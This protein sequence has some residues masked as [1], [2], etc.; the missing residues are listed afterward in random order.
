MAQYRAIFQN[1][2]F[3][4]LATA[5]VVTA[6]LA[7]GQAQAAI[8]DAQ[9]WEG[10]TGTPEA[11][12]ELTI[13]GNVTATNGKEFVLTLSG[14]SNVINGTTTAATSLTA[15]KG[16]LILN[17]DNSTLTIGAATGDSGTKV[18]VNAL[19]IQNG[20][21]TLTNTTGSG[22]T[23]T[24]N[25]LNLGAKGKLV[26]SG[27]DAQAKIGDA[28]KTTINLASGGT[29]EFQSSGSVA[30][31]QLVGTGGTIHFS[32][33][34]A[35]TWTVPNYVDGTAGTAQKQNITVDAGK[36]G[37]IALVGNDTAKKRGVMDFA[38]GSVITLTSDNSSGGSL[39]IDS[40]SA[41]L[42]SLVI[43]REGVDLNSSGSG[44]SGGTITVKGVGSD[45]AEKISTLQTDATVL[46]N[47]LTASVKGS[48]LLDAHSEL[49]IDNRTVKFGTATALTDTDLTLQ[50]ASG[51]AAAGQ[52]SV[53]GATTISAQDMVIESKVGDLS[54]NLTL[55]ADNL[56]LGKT[57]VDMSTDGTGVKELKAKNV[58][59]IGQNDTTDFVLKDK[60]TLSNG[61]KVTGNVTVSG[62]G[63]FAI[64]GGNYSLS[65]KLT[66]NSGSFNVGSATSTSATNVSL[67]TLAINS[68]AANT[69]TVAGADGKTAKLDLTN[70]ELALTGNAQ[71]TTFST[72]NVNTHGQLDI[73]ADNFT[74]ILSNSVND[75]A[76]N[77]SG[78]AGFALSGGII[79]LG[80]DTLKL[81]ANVFT[82]G[83]AANQKISFNTGVESTL[84]AK[85][86]VLTETA[87]GGLN[88]G[89]SGNLAIADT[90]TIEN[91][92]GGTSGLNFVVKTG[93]LAVGS[94]IQSENTA[95][96][97]VLGVSGSSKATLTLGEIVSKTNHTADQGSINV[98]LS[99]I[100]KNQQSGSSLDIEYG[101]WDA[102]SIATKNANI[103]IGAASIN[104]LDLQD[105]DHKWG[106]NAQKLALGASGDT[107]NVYQNI[108]GSTVD[109]ELVVADLS[110]ASGSKINVHGDMTLN[111]NFS[112]GSNA[113]S[114]DDDTYGVDLKSGTIAMQAGGTLTIDNDA[115]TAINISGDTVTLKGYEAGS[116]A[117]ATGSTVK[118]NFAADYGVIS[119]AAI[120]EL[121][122]KLFGKT[123]DTDRLEG[124]LNLGGAELEGLVVNPETNEIAWKD[125]ETKK[126]IISDVTTSK[127]ENAEVTG[128]KSTDTVRGTFGSLTS[129]EMKAGSQIK[130]DENLTL[131]NAA[132][133]QGYFAAQVD[134]DG[135]EGKVLGALGFN[136][137]ANTNL[138][139]KNGGIADKI[140]LGDGSKL[141]VVGNNNETTLTKI[142]GNSGVVSLE[143][144]AL[145]VTHED[146]V[147]VGSLNS[148]A[149][150][151]LAANKLELKSTGNSKI[152]GDLNIA[153]KTTVS[154][155]AKFSGNNQFGDL[156]TATKNAVKRSPITR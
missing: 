19:D 9:G 31:K 95:A 53:S 130:T 61:E 5:A 82:S 78:T 15:E 154:G 135:N 101:T 28:T 63:P 38:S 88:L 16:T 64:D 150:S 153:G 102:Q 152:A 27:S 90:L 155:S 96:K 92:S 45:S 114:P 26:V 105:V 136:V 52:V 145:K 108:E 41:S 141:V 60:L 58:T 79:N 118:L 91:T 43:L 115:L 49:A 126:D 24:L 34:G 46:G 93:N 86:M 99:L 112:S 116:I 84:K 55:A 36:T 4:G 2:Y 76:T 156:F 37:T 18:S 35:N 148:K 10:L 146:G 22:S 14:T 81:N 119:D 120:V 123:A 54:A 107:V 7:A 21:V 80:E 17:E 87:D 29:I 50:V 33:D 11:H 44:T 149:G 13:S 48:V 68:A 42:G 85:N 111:G 94:T 122:K 142:T 143:S 8:T 132:G 117:S 70:T 83:S 138:T 113:T 59:F 109:Q 124:T 73:S 69:I 20:T 3:K 144:G 127:L 67:S 140:T 47:F 129:T 32:G 23:V 1:A 65:D 131:G 77:Q 56:T 139:L 134:K 51:A 71:A 62:T 106:L 98:D 89:D 12:Q 100:G 133:N 72:I 97:L 137:K 147:V 6:G 74:K 75:W 125:V 128:I 25:N 110:T 57:G 151:S 104:A 39:I 66:L 30:G 121:R 40:G 103:D